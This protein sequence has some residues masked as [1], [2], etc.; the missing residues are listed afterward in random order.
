[1]APE[2]VMQCL[3]GYVSQLRCGL[4]WDAQLDTELDLDLAVL[5]LDATEKLVAGKEG[6]IYAGHPHHHSGAINLL[7]DSITGEGEGDDEQLLINLT[8][9][10]KAVTKLIFVVNIDCAEAQQQDF[11]Q[12]PN[13]FWRLLE[14][15]S[16]DILLH[17]DLS[18]LHWSG[19][20]TLFG[21][22]LERHDQH[23]LLVST[24]QPCPFQTLNE[25][26]HHYL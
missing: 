2:V 6:F 14:G 19:I 25:L 7:N 10:P 18:N 17:H 12:L 9:L 21:A 3:P 23:W 22:T 20:T 15:D 8:I 5:C 16:R 26:L 13:A 24:V 11:N 1:M 4:G